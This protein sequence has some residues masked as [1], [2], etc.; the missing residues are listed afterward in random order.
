MN[1]LKIF[2]LGYFIGKSHFQED[3]TQNYLV[4][5]SIHRYFKI[6][7]GKCISTWKSKGLSDETI[8]PYATAGNS[9]TPLI[10]HYGSKVRVKVTKSCLK[11]PN[12]LTYDKEHKVKVYIIYDL[13]ASGSDDNDPTLKNCL[14]GAVT[15]T[16]N[17]DINKYVL[18]FILV[19]RKKTY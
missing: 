13:S 14:F 5:W 4:F 3:G 6:T 12:K 17:T 7:N 19:I 10:D 16:K 18:L 11:Q 15:L 2:D 9:L 1:K 8:T